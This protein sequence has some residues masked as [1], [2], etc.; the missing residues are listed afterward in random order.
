MK[1]P[2][3][4]WFVVMLG[5]AT[6][7]AK[8]KELEEPIDTS[9]EFNESHDNVW[10]ALVSGMAKGSVEKPFVIDTIDKSSGVITTKLRYTNYPGLYGKKV[11]RSRQKTGRYRLSIFLQEIEQRKMLVNV[12]VHLEVYED[13]LFY[14]GWLP[15]ESGGFLESAV[16][17][18]T[19]DGL[20]HLL[21][22]H[23]VRDMAANQETRQV[24]PIQSPASG[25][26][27]IV[28]DTYLCNASLSACDISLKANTAVEITFEIDNWYKVKI[29][30]AEGW[31][32]KDAVRK[33]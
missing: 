10:T 33:R 32:K 9:C 2:R 26:H 11:R 18:N 25:T 27:Y 3:L 30:T 22:I 13:G 21:G 23:P 20:P 7:V 19:S 14:S 12:T 4:V 6:N 16:C 29:G 8:V 5:C 24:E 1:R 28:K 17:L 15:L 31:I